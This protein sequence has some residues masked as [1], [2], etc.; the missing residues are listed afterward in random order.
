M[1][2]GDLLE[3][4]ALLA[5][6]A[7]AAGVDIPRLLAL[8]PSTEPTGTR[9][10]GVGDVEAIETATVAFRDQDFAR[11]SGLARDTAV[12]RLQATLPLLGAQVASEVRPRLYLATAHL[13]MMTGWMSFDVERHD[14]ARGDARACD[15]ALHQAEERFASIDHQLSPPWGAHLDDAGL[16]AW[17]GAAHYALALPGRDPVAASRAVALLRH[18]LSHYGPDF[19][20]HRAQRLPDLAGAHAIAGDIDTAITVGHQALDAVTAV[21]S[22]RAHARLHRLRTVLEPCH[23]SP[24]VAELRDRLTTTA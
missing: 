23:T 14:A 1:N 12:A 5:F 2:R 16:A 21:R 13:A 11:G 10:V 17:Q 15:L 20:G 18:G 9:H 6:G 7:G 22:P 4:V 8:L 19:A 3:E 24:G